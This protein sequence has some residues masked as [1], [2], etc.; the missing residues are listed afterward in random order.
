MPHGKILPY[1]SL[2]TLTQLHA[3]LA[4]KLSA[5][6][7]ETKR[8]RLAIFQVEA[9]M[10]MLSPEVNLRLIAPKRRNVGNPWFKRGTL[11]RA[12]IDTLRKATGP[13]T[14]DDICKA[15]L[16]GRTLRATR[17]QENNLQAAVLAALRKRKDAAVIAEGFP[18]R[19]RL[20]EAAN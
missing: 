3:E 11:Y 10:K 13:M 15:L 4:G 18:Q 6:Q 9:V 20:K 8:L 19:W 14:A 12:V 17:K 1:H 5:N 2:K 7:R 16:V